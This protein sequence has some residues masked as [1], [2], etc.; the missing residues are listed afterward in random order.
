MELFYGDVTFRLFTVTESQEDARATKNLAHEG[1]SNELL[2]ELKALIEARGY[3][4]Q[5]LSADL[6]PIDEASEHQIKS[7]NEVVRRAKTQENVIRG[8]TKVVRIEI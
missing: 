6:N 4:V 5:E 1:L 2:N 7:I 8:K 3:Y